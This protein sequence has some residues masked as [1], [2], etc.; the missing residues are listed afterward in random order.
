[1]KVCLCI[2]MVVGICSTA[3]WA[4]PAEFSS[5]D[6]AFAA[7]APDTSIDAKPGLL[8]K[9]TTAVLEFSSNVQNTEFQCSFDG[10]AYVGCLSPIKRRSLVDGGHTFCVR[11]VD[12]AGTKDDTPACYSW[13]VNTV[14]PMVTI[15]EPSSNAGV[16]TKNPTI[17]GT[18][19]EAS[20]QVHVFIDDKSVG[21]V[22]SDSAGKWTFK[23][24][25]DLGNGDHQLSA[26]ATDAA[27]NLS[28]RSVVTPIKVSTDPPKTV[29]VEQPAKIH[30]SQNAVFSF[31]SPGGTKQF[32]CQLDKAPGFTPCEE[33]WLLKNL[34][35]GP[36]TLRVRAKD[37]AGNVDPAP[38]EYAWTVD[39]TSSPSPCIVQEEASPSETKQGCAAS[40]SS[41]TLALSL[42]GGVWVLTLRRRRA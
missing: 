6:E 38:I 9:D 35:E 24:L 14:A 29:I 10:G 27:G 25:L 18:V 42:L 1:M 39:T 23:A 8:S 28:G 11:A 16:F 20:S 17:T 19:S 3:A 40:G 32:E 15:L 12:G 22:D 26:T 2:G 33:V 37:S 4:G 5:R 31:S 13:T 7:P 30:C 36:H 41:P 34:A 21:D